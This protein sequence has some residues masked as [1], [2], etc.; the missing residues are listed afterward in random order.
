MASLL[1]LASLASLA[2]L[3]AACG[4]TTP[5]GAGG[6]GTTTSSA[7]GTGGSSTTGVGDATSTTSAGGSSSTT[8]STSTT[9]TTSTSTGAGGGSSA[10]ALTAT[11]AGSICKALSRCCDATSVTSYFAPWAQSTLLASFAAKIPPQHAFADD[12]E[13]AAT[14]KQMLDITPFGDWAA[15]VM[16]GRVTFDPAALAACTAT[17]DGAAC[18]HDVSAA[19]YD[20]T[21][22]GFSPPPGGPFQRSMFHRLGKMGDACSPI[23]DGI[24]AAFFGSC[25]PT[26]FFCCYADAQSPGKCA[27]PFDKNGVARAGACA[28]ASKLG[29]TCSVLGNVQVCVTGASCDSVSDKCVS[30]GDAPLALGD[31]CV[32]GSFNLLGICQNSWC[33]LLGSSHC[34]A[35]KAVGSACAGGEE[36]LSSACVSGKCG[37][38]TFCK[39]P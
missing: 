6:A 21:C 14:V 28:P 5:T 3:A 27:L 36:C 13:C 35:P 23:H 4:G 20:G 32:D 18:G 11:A 25:D 12:A 10:D 34:E 8:S 33:D 37:A 38:P 17:L 1:A 16:A 22:L 39:G 31:L 26:G 19:L 7:S 9:S 29:A 15:A 24:G 2:S 30:D